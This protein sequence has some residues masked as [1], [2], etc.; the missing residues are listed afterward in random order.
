MLAALVQRKVGTLL[1]DETFE[2]SGVVCREC[3]WL[4]AEGGCCP[5]DDSELEQHEDV[6]EPAVEAALLQSAQSVYVRHH[7]DLQPL[8]G[9]ASLNRF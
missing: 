3:G 6:V 5:V 2:A 7:P 1:L 9:I 4:G 8:G